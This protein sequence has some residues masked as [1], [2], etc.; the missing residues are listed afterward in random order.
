MARVDWRIVR[1]ALLLCCLLTIAGAGDPPQPGKVLDEARQARRSAA[2]LPA[3]TEDY[4][5]D[6]DGGAD[7]KP[8]PATKLDPVLGRNTWLVWSGGNDRFWDKMTD[9]TFGAFDLLK[10]IAYDPSKP[11]DR[12]DRWKALGL[13]NEPC[14]QA[15]TAPD[16]D[17]FGL[18]LDVRKP[19]CAPDPFEDATKYPGVKIG[20]RGSTVPVGSL[21]GYASGVIGLRLFPNP[22]F[23]DAAKAKWNADAYF[24]GDAKMVRPYR[25]GMSC[26][27]CHVGPSPVHP[28]ADPA[29]PQFAD[30]SSTVGAQYMWVD[31]LFIYRRNPDNYFFQLVHTYRPGAMDTSLVSTDNINNPRTMNAIYSLG[32]RLQQA[33]RWGRET[34]AD[35]QL[36]N[37]Q[38]NNYLSSGPLTQFF[39]KPNV[40]WAPRVLKDGSDSVGALGALNRVYLNIG[41]FSEEWLLHFNPVVGGKPITP[42][43]IAS[44]EKNSSYWQAT[45]AWTPHTAW[46]FLQAAKPDRLK[47]APGGAKYLTTDTSVLDRGKTVFA[48]TCARCHSSKIPK[49]AAGLDPSGCAGPGYLQCWNKYWAWTKT[50]DYKTQMRAIVSAPDFLEGNFL[51]TEARVPVT[52]MQTNACSPLATNALAG[53]IWDNFSSQSYKTLPSVGTITVHDPFTGKPWQY[54][55]PAGGRGYTRPPSLIS[56]WSTAPFLLNNT[57]GQNAFEQDPSVDARMR[58]F[59]ASI[60]QMLWPDKRERDPSLGNTNQGDPIYLIDRTTQ[61]SNISIPADYVPET[62]RPL[63]ARLH[64]LLPKLFGTDGSLTIGPFPKGLPVNLLSNLQPLPESDRLLDRIRH[65]ENL[66][67]LL[68]DLKL[69]LLTLPSGATDEQKVGAIGSKMGSELLALNKCPDFEVNRGHYFGTGMVPGEPALS[70]SDKRALIEFLKTF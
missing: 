45:E 69:Y 47:D 38:F 31:R 66:A 10:I 5:H 57:V 42:I 22:D 52:L 23:D 65:V 41:L 51:S 67:K 28:P 61:D 34:L 70:D 9:Y 32:D 53:N 18:L 33:L 56:L 11:I 30:L 63:S 4:F 7:L 15:P 43:P 55:M 35:G 29:N 60:E 50:E 13:I 44:A 2:S 64:T 21:Y 3:P 59:Q 49:P 27:F 68:V 1:R 19:G 16:P 40:S 20:A 37:K 39:Q 8:D 14:M 25:V 24:K 17:R 54:K 46:F 6:M 62:F 58:V 48:E 36:N 12:S 26:G